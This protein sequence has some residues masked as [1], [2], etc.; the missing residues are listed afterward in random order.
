M[1]G[2]WDRCQAALFPELRDESTVVQ[3]AL[4]TKPNNCGRRQ[5]CSLADLTSPL[6]FRA[7]GLGLSLKTSAESDDE[8]RQQRLGRGVG[9]EQPR[10]EAAV[11]ET[12]VIW[13]NRAGQD[14]TG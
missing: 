3:Q 1:S 9:Q 8:L 6:A 10:A 13:M 5:P 11:D 12:R 4:W 7:P 2:D 14:R